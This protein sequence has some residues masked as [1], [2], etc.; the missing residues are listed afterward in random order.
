MP[1]G[2]RKFDAYHLLIELNSLNERIMALK[3]T[4]PH[5]Q[6]KIDSDSDFDLDETRITGYQI[7]NGF[8]CTLKTRQS[9]NIQNILFNDLIFHV[10]F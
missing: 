4:E 2:Y 6:T 8:N 10:R 7:C 3:S 9:V 1:L 5:G